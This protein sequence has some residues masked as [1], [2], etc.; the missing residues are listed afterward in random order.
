MAD[1]FFSFMMDNF[2]TELVVMGA[3]VALM[4]YSL[5]IDPSRMKSFDAFYEKYGR[6]VI[7][8]AQG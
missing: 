2:P 3:K 5:P 6:Y 7:T 8:A 4:Q 1:N